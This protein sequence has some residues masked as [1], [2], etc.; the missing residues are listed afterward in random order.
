MELEQTDFEIKLIER[1]L[2]KGHFAGNKSKYDF[3]S[4]KIKGNH[5]EID[6]KK[7]WAILN[8]AHTWMGKNM[9]C[10]KVELRYKD[11]KCYL[12]RMS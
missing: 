10:F 5:I 1:G 3:E 8:T 2:H 11:G 9:N 12:V 6:Y 7:R 4:L